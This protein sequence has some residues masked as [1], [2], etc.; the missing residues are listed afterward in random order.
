MKVGYSFNKGI[1]V[2]EEERHTVDSVHNTYYLELDKTYDHYISSLFSSFPL[3]CTYF[4]QILSYV[5]SHALFSE[6]FN[7]LQILP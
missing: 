2:R 6:D 3:S 5:F 1:L 7:S 4:I